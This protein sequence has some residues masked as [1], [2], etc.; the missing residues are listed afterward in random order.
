M[1]I[2]SSMS[3][4]ALRPTAPVEL[5]CIPKHFSSLPAPSPM[6]HT[7]LLGTW[8]CPFHLPQSK[9]TKPGQLC[10]DGARSLAW[11]WEEALGRGTRTEL[12]LLYQSPCKVASML[13]ECGN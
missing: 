2:D 7:S 13:S 11:S 10:F 3:I 1:G 6:P 12:R 5:C 4:L 9:E 8:H